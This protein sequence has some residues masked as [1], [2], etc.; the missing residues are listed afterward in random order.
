[1][2]WE[3]HLAGVGNIRTLRKLKSRNFSSNFTAR[4]HLIRRPRTR[5]HPGRRRRL[6][7]VLVHPAPA[8][9]LPGPVRE[10]L[11]RRRLL[12]A[13]GRC[14]FAARRECFVGLMEHESGGNCLVR[15]EN[16]EFKNFPTAKGEKKVP[17]AA[18]AAAATAVAAAA[19]AAAA[20]ADAAAA[21]AAAAATAAAAP[22]AAA[23]AAPAA[24]SLK[25]SLQ[26]LNIN[27]LVTEF[28][29]SKISS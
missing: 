28:I 19:A 27:D 21:A 7:E 12:V 2:F 22:A 10:L 17:A 24:V 1:M 13:G 14:L 20:A 18:A 16:D 15:E 26:I 5:G 9:N 11:P 23:A 6:R 25:E 4:F 8:E 3:N 29:T